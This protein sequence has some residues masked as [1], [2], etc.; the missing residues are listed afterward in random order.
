MIVFFCYIDA[1]VKEPTKKSFSFLDEGIWTAL[2][3][4]LIFNLATKCKEILQHST[5][6]SFTHKL[7]IED[8]S[9]SQSFACF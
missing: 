1:T 2:A 9:V 5:C 6:I 4:P 8:F 7:T 3:Q